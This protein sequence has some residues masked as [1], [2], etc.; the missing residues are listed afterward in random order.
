MKASTDITYGEFD[1]L[2]AGTDFAYDSR[3][4][5][6]G[7]Q[8]AGIL[9]CAVCGERDLCGCRVQCH[10]NRP[11]YEAHGCNVTGCFKHPN[12]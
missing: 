2:F 11:T 6:A 4:L 7:E 5:V 9:G 3:P 1:T 8:G 10:R 12:G